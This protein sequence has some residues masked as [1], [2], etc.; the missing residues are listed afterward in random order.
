MRL[1]GMPPALAG[2]RISFAEFR[3]F[4][5]MWRQLRLLSGVLPG[6]LCQGCC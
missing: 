3:Q 6:V 1:Q 4:R 5:E 2:L